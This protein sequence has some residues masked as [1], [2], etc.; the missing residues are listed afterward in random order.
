MLRDQMQKI[1]GTDL[2]LAGLCHPCPEMRSLVLSEMSQFRVPPN[3]FAD[4]TVPKLKEIA[5][6]TSCAWHTRAAAMLSLAQIAQMKHCSR[7]DRAETIR[8]MLKMLQSESDE[9]ENVHFALVKALGTVLKEGGQSAAGGGIMLLREDES[10]LSQPGLRESVS[11]ANALSDLKVYSAGLVDW[12]EGG[13]SPIAQGR[14]PIR[15]VHFLCE[16]VAASKNSQMAVR[17]VNSLLHRLHS[18]SFQ[19]S[20]QE[21]LLRG[22]CAVHALVAADGWSQVLPFLEFGD[23]EQR[24]R[25]LEAAVDM[26]VRFEGEDATGRLARCLLLETGPT[27]ADE[28][29]ETSMLS[30]VLKR[31]AGKYRY[32]S[33]RENSKV[34][35]FLVNIMGQSTGDSQQV[36]SR[37]LT[38][39]EKA[40]VGEHHAQA[41]PFDA[42]GEEEEWKTEEELTDD[43]DAEAIE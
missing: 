11:V 29:S 14:W 41:T 25:V 24:A 40:H 1:R 33:F 6:D 39:I 31:E 42:D 26:K 8:W 34:F 28:R 12:L 37:H 5:E 18:Y 43:E 38:D 15:H 23:A 10:V 16:N 2:L 7:S 20:D 21:L 3:P 35:V 17:L 13:A 36:V 30:Y 32:S 22:L 19:M 4:E 27:R 9:L